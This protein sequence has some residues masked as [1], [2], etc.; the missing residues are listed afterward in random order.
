[1]ARADGAQGAFPRLVILVM[2]VVF[3]LVLLTFT[4]EVCARLDDWLRYDAPL[5]QKYSSERLRGRDTGGKYSYNLPRASFEKWRHNSLGFRSPEFDLEKRQG[6]TRIVCVGSSESYGLYESAG[7]EW[8]AQLQTLVPPSRCQVVNASV[9]GLS[10]NSFRSYLEKHVFPLHPDIVVLVVNPIFYVTAQSRSELRKSNPE[11][12]GAT[13]PQPAPSGKQKVLAH[14]RIL[15]KLKQ[16]VKQA[17]SSAWPEAFKRYQLESTLKQVQEQERSLA[18]RKPMQAIPPAYVKGFEEELTRTVELI[19]SHRARVILT[20]YP[21]LIS[22][23]NLSIYPEIFLDNRR[24]CIELS[25]AGLLDAFTRFNEATARISRELGVTFVDTQLALPK[26]TEFF[27]DNVHYTD[28]GARIFA[29]QVLR[30]VDPSMLYPGRDAARL[31]ES[32]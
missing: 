2:K 25:L 23:D 3:F 20:S 13:V 5:L 30:G 27:G 1:M 8:P 32:R 21:A 29:E 12:A 9:V 22:R 10:L 16:V 6:I 24:F 28:K 31:P 14:L 17:V 18:G 4:M 7:K 19:R 11:H 26:S 15:P